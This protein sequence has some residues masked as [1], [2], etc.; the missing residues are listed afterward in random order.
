[1]AKLGNDYYPEL[2][3]CC[4]IV[5][6]PPS[7]AWAVRLSKRWMDP[8]TASKIELWTPADTARVLTTHFGGEQRVPDWLGAAATRRSSDAWSLSFM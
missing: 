2:M 7:A 5:N 6:G 4:C 8:V 1:M 3:G